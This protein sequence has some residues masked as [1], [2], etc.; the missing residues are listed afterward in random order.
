MPGS[1]SP[2]QPRS[3]VGIKKGAVP[4]GH[5]SRQLGQRRLQQ[6]PPKPHPL[7]ALWDLLPPPLE[8]QV[9][10]FHQ[11]FG[12]ELPL[13]SHC[14]IGLCD[15]D[16]TID[17]TAS[18]GGIHSAASAGSQGKSGGEKIHREQLW[19]GTESCPTLR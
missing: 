8:G 5:S 7:C 1:A 18:G 2:L 12:W 11:G 17:V 3:P 14:R 16:V 15:S 9:L 19:E 13:P 6:G 4:E 10:V